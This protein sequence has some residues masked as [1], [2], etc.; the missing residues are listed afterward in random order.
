MSAEE[1]AAKIIE[2]SIIMAI[3]A[4]YFI[5]GSIICVGAYKMRTLE[6]RGWGFAGAIVSIITGILFIQLLVGIWCIVVLNNQL[7]KDGFEEEKPPEV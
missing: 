3:A 1:K 6:S 7:V 5:M 2:R 4:F